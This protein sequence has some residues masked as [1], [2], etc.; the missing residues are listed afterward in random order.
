MPK[1]TELVNPA[2]ASGEKDGRPWTLKEVRLDDGKTATGF[3]EIVVGDEVEVTY[4]EKYKN[5]SYKKPSKADIK[6][7]GFQKQ[8]DEI[9]ATVNK[10]LTI[11]QT[12]PSTN[13][14]PEDV[15]LTNEVE[16]PDL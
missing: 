2:K 16:I 9:Q 3:D 4:N 6:M 13:T 14:L 11:V 8:L 15:D 12:G 1:I 10:I 5:W 7:N